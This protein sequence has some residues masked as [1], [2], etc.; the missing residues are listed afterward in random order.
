MLREKY[1]N[2]IKVTDQIV[3]K[4]FDWKINENAVVTMRTGG[5]SV[6]ITYQDLKLTQLTEKEKL[7]QVRSGFNKNDK[8]KF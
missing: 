6:Q 8:A 3:F 1:G 2:P 4:D 5:N 7:G